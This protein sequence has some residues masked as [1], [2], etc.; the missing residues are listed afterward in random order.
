MRR[1]LVPPGT[2]PLEEAA[3]RRVLT[4]FRP[5]GK[6]HIGHL[7]GN[8]K[9][10]VT[11]QGS[12]EVFVFLADWHMLSTDYDR[13]GEL[14]VNTLDLV[15]D[16]IAAGL[17][18]ERAAIYRQSDLHEVAEL[19]LYFSMITPLSWLERNP[20]FKQ[21]LSELSER[22]IAT[23][24]FLGYPVLQLA[25]ITIVK[26]EVV[27][28]G[29]DQLPHLE[30]GREI[31]RR[32]HSLFGRQYFPEPL[33]LL[34][35]G[36]RVPGS[37]GRKMSKSYGNAIFLADPPEDVQKKVRSY[38][39]DPQ[40]IYLKDPGRPEICAVYALHELF[41]DP[42]DVAT[43]A[44]ECRG[45][46]RGCVACKDQLAANLNR[47]LEPIR[48]RREEAARPGKAVEV[49]DSGFE[50][51]EP[52]AEETLAVAREMIGVGPS[53]VLGRIAKPARVSGHD[54]GSAAAE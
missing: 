50:K 51:V 44:A 22:E 6:L 19:A 29:E 42:V 15:V 24:G 47:V 32:F 45:G 20:T 34:S 8:I 18:P 5:T 41:T 23:H 16:L 30:L 10:L 46:E 49:L 14:E 7:F 54:T 27:P 35:E 17:D 39:T 1:H 38:I 9:N 13:T 48:L 4:G 43:V 11:L 31:L 36:P 21:Q 12:A 37:D 53:R 2:I 26:G 3:G 25:D 33:G 52:I 28:V 40:K